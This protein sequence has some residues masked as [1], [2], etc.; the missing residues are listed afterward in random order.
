MHARPKWENKILAQ[1]ITELDRVKNAPVKLVQPLVRQAQLGASFG[2]K[3]PIGQ[4]LTSSPY[5]VLRL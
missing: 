5:R 1:P 2:V 3:V 4:S